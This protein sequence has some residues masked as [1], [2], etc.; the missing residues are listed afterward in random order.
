MRNKSDFLNI[1]CVYWINYSESDFFF[2]VRFYFKV[3]YYLF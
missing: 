1:Y 3:K 2:L